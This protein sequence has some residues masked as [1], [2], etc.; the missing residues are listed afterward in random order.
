MPIKPVATSNSS[1][2]HALKNFGLL[3][4]S[5]ELRL[6]LDIPIEPVAPAIVKIVGRKTA[7]MVLELPARGARRL[8]CQRHARL[9]RRSTAFPEVAWRAGCD[10]IVPCRPPALCP[11]YHM[12][13]GELPGIAAILAGEA[14]TQEQVEPR[15]GGILRRPDILLECDDRRQPHRDVRAVDFSLIMLDDGDAIEEH[16]LDRRLPR[17]KTERIIAERR[18]IGVQ[19]QCRATFGMSDQIGM[20]HNRKRTL[21][22]RSAR[23]PPSSRR[24]RGVK[25]TGSRLRCRRSFTELRDAI[26]TARR[27]TRRQEPVS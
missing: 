11:G 20:I 26:M 19:H 9:P 16:G 17:P 14:I 21:C 2:R 13:E 12:I 1:C 4:N 18:I 25:P 10:D 6:Q 27:A 5:A 22:C 7:A 24:T 23:R 15:E 3:P 8:Q